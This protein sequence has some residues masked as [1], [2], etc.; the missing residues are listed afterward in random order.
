MRVWVLKRGINPD[1]DS[2][3]TYFEDFRLERTRHLSN[4][5]NFLSQESWPERIRNW[6]IRAGIFSV[7]IFVLSV[8]FM[9]FITALYLLPIWGSILFAYW[10]VQNKK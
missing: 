8:I 2:S 1:G 10:L 7:I 4:G 9:G 3:Y 5:V 6:L